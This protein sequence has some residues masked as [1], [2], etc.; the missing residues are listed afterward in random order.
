MQSLDSHKK[1]RRRRRRDTLH[2]QTCL[3]YRHSIRH[4]HLL[5]HMPMSLRFRLDLKIQL[6]L[7]LLHQNLLF[8]R[9]WTIRLRL[10][11]C[12]K[13]GPFLRHNL[14]KFPLNTL[15]H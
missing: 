3:R 15:L 6:D 13:K 12:H 11:Q 1:I 8:R 9:R 4:R 5:R 7:I 2:Y 14:L 10:R